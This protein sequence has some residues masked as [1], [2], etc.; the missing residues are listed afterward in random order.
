MAFWLHPHLAIRDSCRV[1]VTRRY[2]LGLLSAVVLF[3]LR[4]SRLLG[5]LRRE[6]NNSYFFAQNRTALVGA[7]CNRRGRP[8]KKRMAHLHVVLS[9]FLT[10][11]A[12]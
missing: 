4:S 2:P 1:L 7:R 10:T 9:G 8:G 6:Y 12:Y 5:A 3:T 11:T